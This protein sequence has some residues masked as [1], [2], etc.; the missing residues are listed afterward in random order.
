MEAMMIWISDNRFWIMPVLLVT[1]IYYVVKVVKQL[2]SDG[3]GKARSGK[4][5]LGKVR[6]GMVR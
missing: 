5:R 4:A 6:R 2:F 3:L 1:E